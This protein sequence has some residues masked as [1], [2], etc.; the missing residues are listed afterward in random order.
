VFDVEITATDIARIREAVRTW[1]KPPYV[2]DKFDGARIHAHLQAWMHFVET[3][4][5]GW[6]ISEY[7][8][9][10]GVR[11]WIQLAIEYSAPATSE[12]IRAA[13]QVADR[14]FQEKMVPAVPWCRHSST[15][16]LRE[17]PYFWET[18]TIHP[19]L[20]VGEPD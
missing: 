13:V 14:V 18:H 17:H 15:M 16:V 1:G 3:N 10:I 9:E 2:V 20:A 11:T 12:R 6:D 4:W 19:E 8:H 7:D 5:D